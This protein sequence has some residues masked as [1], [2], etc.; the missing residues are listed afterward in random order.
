MA[1]QIPADAPSATKPQVA[2]IRELLKERVVSPQDA[3]RLRRKLDAGQIA[4]ED[5]RVNVIPWLLRQP[6]RPG[7]VPSRIN[8]MPKAEKKRREEPVSIQRPRRDLAEHPLPT[9]G[10]FRY[11]NEI[12]IIVPSR[13][14][15]GQFYAKRMVVTPPRLTTSGATVNFDYSN[16]PGMIWYLYEEHRMPPEAIEELMV[17]H[18]VCI[19]PGCFRVLRAAKSVAAGV[20]KRHAEK[21]G[22]PWGKKSLC[23]TRTP[24]LPVR[25]SAFP[26]D[27]LSTRLPS[28]S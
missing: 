2:F 8:A 4:K 17:Q 23:A 12:Y 6:V 28:G 16:A 21:L 9:H 26:A 14:N 10:V 20:G 5:A 13:R 22:I 3:E 19:Y 24:E 15:V 18:K 11:E 1:V 7:V 25:H 27:T